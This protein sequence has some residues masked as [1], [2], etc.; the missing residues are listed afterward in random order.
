MGNIRRHHSHCQQWVAQPL[1]DERGNR[2]H[3]R[4]YTQLGP[5]DIRE[6]F[7]PATATY[8]FFSSANRTFSKTHH[9]FSHNT[10]FHKFLNTE[11]TQHIFSDHSR[12]KT[13]NQYQKTIWTNHKL[14]SK[15]HAIKQPV[16]QK[17]NHK[18][19]Y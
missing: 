15:Q 1:K 17:T 12:M 7:Y 19:N 11:I 5:R 16:G 9:L 10:H 2:R 6:T 14:Q 13:G 18:V 8:T 3:E 4:Y